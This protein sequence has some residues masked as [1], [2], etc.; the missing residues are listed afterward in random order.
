[1]PK[2]HEAIVRISARLWNSTLVEDYSHLDYVIISSYAEILLASIN[3]VHQNTSD[4]ISHA[5]TYAYPESLEGAE[6]ENV[7]PWIVVS[8][9]YTS[10]FLSLHNN[11]LTN[12]FFYFLNGF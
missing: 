6:S 2:N 5:T 9:I 10:D 11:T 1:M 4:D 12:T 3:N 8:G 7:P